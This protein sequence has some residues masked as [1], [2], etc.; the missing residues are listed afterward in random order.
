[1]AMLNSWGVFEM[2][3]PPAWM[4]SLEVKWCWINDIPK[5]SGVSE[6]QIPSLFGDSTNVDVGFAREMLLKYPLVV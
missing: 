5:T 4:D 1:M 2:G 3:V 6:T